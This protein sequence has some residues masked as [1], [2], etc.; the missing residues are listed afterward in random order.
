MNPMLTA[1]YPECQPDYTAIWDTEHHKMHASSRI[2]SNCVWASNKNGQ[3]SE[4]TATKHASSSMY[5]NQSMQCN[6]NEEYNQVCKHHSQLHA[7][8]VYH[9]T[10]VCHSNSNEEKQ[11]EKINLNRIFLMILKLEFKS[12]VKVLE[13]RLLGLHIV[14]PHLRTVTENGRIQK[15]FLWILALNHQ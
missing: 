14:D 1:P 5:Q 7:T 8:Q 3:T 4:S 6:P 15:V 13:Q 9:V 12:R 2:P 11:S 10:Q